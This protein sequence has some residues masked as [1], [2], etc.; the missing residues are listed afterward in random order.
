MFKPV[1]RGKHLIQSTVRSSL[2]FLLFKLLIWYAFNP[3]PV[4]R[5]V[6]VKMEFT[7][8]E[9]STVR[10]VPTPKQVRKSTTKS[11]NVCMLGLSRTEFISLFLE[12]HDEHKNYAA[13]PSRGPT[14]QLVWSGVRYFFLYLS[15]VITFS[16][17]SLFSATDVDTD[18][19][20][21]ACRQAILAKKSLPK[22]TVTFNVDKM[23]PFRIKKR[24]SR[25][26]HASDITLLNF[27]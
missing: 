3:A 24:V 15:Y 21:V 16:L 13:G 1:H 5:L 27:L 10:G 22:L 4:E 23:E 8:V 11:F 12:S 14:F 26:G 9:Q 7:V 25:F 18:E 17:S 2:S 20:F 6:Q 19:E